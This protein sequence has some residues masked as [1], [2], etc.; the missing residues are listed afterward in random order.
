[1]SGT[2]FLLTTGRQ[3]Q[4][5]TPKTSARRES[6]EKLSRVDGPETST[7]PSVLFHFMAQ[8]ADAP[9]SARRTNS[10]PEILTRSKSRN[11]AGAE[12]VNKTIENRA[13]AVLMLA[14]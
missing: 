10:L 12:A 2:P 13:A 8:P 11:A 9:Q 6:M 5:D 7:S 4:T 3:S 14:R 1:M